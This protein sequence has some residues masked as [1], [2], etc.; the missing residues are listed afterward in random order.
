VEIMAKTKSM[1]RSLEK[2]KEYGWEYWIVEYYN[3]YARRKIDFFNFGDILCLDGDRTLVIQATGS[4]IAS[5]RDK[6]MENEFV[7]PWLSAIG[8]EFQIWSW[9]KLKKVR[10][11]KATYWDCKVTLVLL[12]QGQIYFEEVKNV[13]KKQSAEND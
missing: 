13:R 8:N 10:G 7:I 2:I 11:K 3:H 5:H 9:R 6:I 1:Q 4:D 12:V